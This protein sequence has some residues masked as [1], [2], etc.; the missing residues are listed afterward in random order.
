MRITPAFDQVWGNPIDMPKQAIDRS[1]SALMQ[2]CGFSVR[3]R[4]AHPMLDRA[5]GD[6]TQLG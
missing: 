6:T 5:A 1:K 3:G 2:Q 4:M